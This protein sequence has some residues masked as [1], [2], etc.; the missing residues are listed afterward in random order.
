MDSFDGGDGCQLTA[1][2]LD[3]LFAEGTLLILRHEAPLLKS[4]R[5]P[6]YSVLKNILRGTGAVICD[7]HAYGLPHN[8]YF[9]ILAMSCR[10]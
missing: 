7:A 5:L 3:R 1:L 8:S 10:R 2:E 4:Q 6:P 9:P